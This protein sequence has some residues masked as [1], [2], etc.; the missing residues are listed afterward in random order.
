VVGASAILLSVVS[1]FVAISANRTQERMLAASIWPSLLFSTSNTAPDGTPQLGIDLLNRGTGPARVRWLE[2]YY[3]DAPLADWRELLRRCCAS[4]PAQV[5]EVYGISSGVQNRVLGADEWVRMLQIQPEDA[6][7]AIWK[8]LDRER[9]NVRM[10]AC[11]CSVL[12]DCWLFDSG[13]EDPEP[14]KRC[15]APGPVLWR[16]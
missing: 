13:R 16:G 10:R 9:H 12:D 11:Y 7:D 5:E 14:V 1:L 8:A 2:M 3:R 6:P 4:S 15:P